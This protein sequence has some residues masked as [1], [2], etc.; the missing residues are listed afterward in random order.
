M[1]GEATLLRIEKL[2]KSF[3]GRK[4]VDDVGF[5][6]N[7]QEVVGLLGLN[8]AGKTTTFKMVVGLLWPDAGHVFFK[9]EDP[10]GMPMYRRARKGIGYLAQKPSVFADLAV[11]DNLIAILETLPLKREERDDRLAVEEIQNI[12]NTLRQK[13]YGILLTDHS[14]R[15]T[16]SVTD[17]SYV[18]AEGRIISH[19]S[20]QEILKD[21]NARKYYLGEKFKM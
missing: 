10:A 4:V 16:L 15:E 7:A 17:R 8:G 1:S 12:I 9:G 13:G 6:V 3:S 19:G 11:E 5:N 14:V 18:I 2:D 21:P 20:P